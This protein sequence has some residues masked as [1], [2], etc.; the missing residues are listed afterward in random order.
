MRP[1]RAEAVGQEVQPSEDSGVVVPKQDV[2][3]IRERRR[4]CGVRAHCGEH[5]EHVRSG[6]QVCARVPGA[7]Y[8]WK[9]R[10]SVVR[11][12]N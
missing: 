8:G 6:H 5:L 3:R 1:G 2:Q 12:K 4:D 11:S 7:V 9:S 10:G